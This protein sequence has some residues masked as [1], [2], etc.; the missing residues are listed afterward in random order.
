MS[1]WLFPS[2]FS[3]PLNS[4]VFNI[5]GQKK[6]EQL[7][8]GHKRTDGVYL[9]LFEGLFLEMNVKSHGKAPVL[10][11]ANSPVERFSKGAFWGRMDPN[12]FDQ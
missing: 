12:T 1:S 3:S 7:P 5:W 10:S 2:F 9:L 11:Q 6:I 8:L 4:S